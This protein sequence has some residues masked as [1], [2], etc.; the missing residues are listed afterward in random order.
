MLV[1]RPVHIPPHAVDLDVGLVD[2]PPV[3][4]RVP[5]E[6]GR[7]GQQRREPLHPAVDRDVIDLDTAFG[8]QFLDV[9]V[10]IPGVWVSSGSLDEVVRPGGRLVVGGAGLE[11]SVQDADEPVGELAQRGVVAG[12]AGALPVVVGAGAGRAAQRR[13]RLGHQR[14]DEPV[15]V[16]EPGATVF[17]LPEA[18]VIGLVPA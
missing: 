2:E 14:V 4:R 9:A 18:R 5:G 7:I 15:V 17:F 6:A 10:D 1:D 8:Q 16:H 13:E 3:T 12:A 11:A